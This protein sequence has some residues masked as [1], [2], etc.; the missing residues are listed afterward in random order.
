MTTLQPQDRLTMEVY[1]AE[2]ADYSEF[3]DRLIKVREIR[4]ARLQMQKPKTAA[5]I[6]EIINGK[7]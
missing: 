7:L 1:K 3:A 6:K 4:Q 5:L 2:H